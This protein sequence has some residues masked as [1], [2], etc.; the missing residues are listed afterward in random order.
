MLKSIWLWMPMVPRSELIDLR[1][2]HVVLGMDNRALERSVMELDDCNAQLHADLDEA[3]SE[4]DKAIGKFEY[5]EK[6]RKELE[7][8]LADRDSYVRFLE[9]QL[10]QYMDEE[11]G[12]DF[13]DDTDDLIDEDSC[14]ICGLDEYDCDCDKSDELICPDCGEDETECICWEEQ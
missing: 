6:A 12:E 13:D 4:R 1:C 5:V 14:P 11:P 9:G 7:A 10:K 8:K 3:R 2:E